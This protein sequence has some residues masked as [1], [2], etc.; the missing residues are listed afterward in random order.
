MAI[1][2]VF[3]TLVAQI[4]LVSGT[5]AATQQIRSSDRNRLFAGG[6]DSLV[7]R[8]GLGHDLHGRCRR[9]NSA[10]VPAVAHI[11]WIVFP[12]EVL[13]VVDRR[14][15]PH[16]VAIAVAA[17]MAAKARRSIEIAAI[18]PATQ[19]HAPVAAIIPAMTAGSEGQNG[20]NREND[21]RVNG[22][23][24]TDDMSADGLFYEELAKPK[25]KAIL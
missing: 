20:K 6:A 16:A 8:C 13:T 22:F 17:A 18:V 19:S 24:G 5:P 23:H 1:R 12:R 9:Q 25:K 3:K 15:W 10:V 11:V 2:V 7:G 21:Q 14:L 4:C